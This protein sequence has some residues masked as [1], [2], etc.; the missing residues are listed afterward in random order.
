MTLTEK[1]KNKKPTNQKKIKKQTTLSEETE[2]KLEKNTG[3]KIYLHIKST[4]LKWTV[5][6]HLV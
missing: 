1:N 6:W 5:Q 4:V 3:I 2:N